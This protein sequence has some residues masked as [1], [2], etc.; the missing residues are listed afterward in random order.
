M[1]GISQH[2]TKPFA[3]HPKYCNECCSALL[4][5]IL[6]RKEYSPGPNCTNVLY[7]QNLNFCQILILIFEFKQDLVKIV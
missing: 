6:I 1:N 2:I 4:Y 3:W 5:R 7:L